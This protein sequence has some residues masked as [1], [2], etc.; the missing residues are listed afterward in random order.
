MLQLWSVTIKHFG[1]CKD[2]QWEHSIQ[3]AIKSRNQADALRFARLQY[4]PN[5]W[6][7]ASIIDARLIGE[8]RAAEG[9][10]VPQEED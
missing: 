2:Q 9:I 7:T 3:I 8:L 10:T 6:D 1:L 4:S 5:W